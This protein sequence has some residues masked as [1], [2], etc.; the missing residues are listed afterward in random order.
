ME[1]Q[2]G[3]IWITINQQQVYCK[4]RTKKVDTRK[5]DSLLSMALHHKPSKPAYASHAY[6][7]T[8]Y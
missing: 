1:V 5:S 4:S 6:A 2:L 3:S 8:D 7:T